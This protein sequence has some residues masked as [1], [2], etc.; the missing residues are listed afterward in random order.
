ML[1]ASQ[2]K[3]LTFLRL[4]FRLPKLTSESML[5]ALGLLSNRSQRVKQAQ[6]LTDKDTKRVLAYVARN[7]L[8]ARNK[9]ML[10]LSWLSGMRVG[11]I[12]ALSVGDVVDADGNVRNEIHLKAAQTKGNKG[13][14]VLLNAQAQAEIAIYVGTLRQP[15]PND[16]LFRS[17]VGKRF[18]ANSLCQVFLRI[19]DDAGLDHATS[20]SGRRTFITTLAHKGVS[21]RVL[22]ELAGHRSIATTQ[23]YIELNENVLR[24]AVELL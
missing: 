18:S 1:A 5:F 22:A 23:R 16:P 7:A 4:Q 17:R 24:A 19:Y 8:A 12:A 3:S 20:H 14:T 15:T 13:R 2:L 10:Q 21:V 6:V 9:C 11:E